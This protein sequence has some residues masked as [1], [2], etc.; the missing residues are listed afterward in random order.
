VV[1]FVV[2][3]CVSAG[4]GVIWVVVARCRLMA[5][6]TW[7]RAVRTAAASSLLIPCC[8]TFLFP[9]SFYL[10]FAADRQ[11]SSVR[12]EHR[13]AALNAALGGESVFQFPFLITEVR[14]PRGEDDE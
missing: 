11:S 6:R 2:W 13:F 10:P 4:N 14:L 3:C 9:P 5:N 8:S 7:A 12:Q 1:L